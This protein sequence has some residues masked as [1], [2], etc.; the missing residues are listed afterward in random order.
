MSEDQ[1]KQIL[2]VDDDVDILAIL[3]KDLEQAGYVVHTAIDIDSSIDLLMRVH[4]DLALVDIILEAEITSEKILNFIKEDGHINSNIPVFVMSA[5]MSDRYET[6]IKMKC[7]FVIS[8]IKKPIM[9]GYIFDYL[10]LMTPKNHGE[11][12]TSSEDKVADLIST[13]SMYFDEADDVEEKEKNSLFDSDVHHIHGECQT[14]DETQRIA[15]QEL[16]SEDILYQGHTD[17]LEEGIEAAYLGKTDHIGMEDEAYAGKTDKTGIEKESYKGKTEKIEIEEESYRGKTDKLGNEELISVKGSNVEKESVTHVKGSKEDLA[18]E[19]T[20]VNGKKEFGEND[21]VIIS[22]E[23]EEYAEENTMV[24]GQ[25]EVIKDDNRIIKGEKEVIKDDNRIIKGEKEVIKDDNRM[26]KGEKEVIKDDNRM[27]KGE[28]EV[29]KDDNRMIKGEKFVSEKNDNTIKGSTPSE[30]SSIEMKNR[31]EDQSDNSKE[32]DEYSMVG[33]LAELKVKRKKEHAE[34][35]EENT[36][37]SGMA[38]LKEK[39]KKERAELDEENTTLS[40]IAE[41]KEKRKKERAEL[42]EENTTLSGIAEL[43]EKRKAKEVEEEVEASWTVT[44]KPKDKSYSQSQTKEDLVNLNQRNDLGQTPLMVAA[45]QGQIELLNKLLAGG[46]DT[47][48]LCRQGRNAL[49]Y[50]AMSGNQEVINAVLRS[51]AKIQHKD[52]KG[53]DPLAFAVQSGSVAAVQALIKGGA[54]LESKI[55]GK[56][57]LM[58]A[59]EQNN[60]DVTKV[61]IAAGIN[62]DARDPKGQTASDIARKNKFAKVFQFIEAFKALKK[63]KAA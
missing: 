51:G 20:L 50:A 25:K 17:H 44:G 32:S 21:S 37:L 7:P 38:E 49:H 48:L 18:N 4:F 41:L 10:E 11:E 40:G 42:D 39:R 57:Y 19:I 1:Q 9:P 24:K 35:E 43:K 30:V 55:N 28:K 56:T 13:M 26:I 2:I 59:V 31:T 6:A 23:R 54:R 61:L 33:G 22:G 3:R 29:I 62:L 58:M 47:N 16:D 34:F 12:M 14:A 60:L 46:G 45:S 53:N 15:G 27:I 52:A 36:T 63:K 5:H 8:C